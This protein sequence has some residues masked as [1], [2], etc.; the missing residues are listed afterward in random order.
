MAA[1]TYTT[2]L[3]TL[4]TGNDV[5]NWDE[6]SNSSWDDASP[7]VAESDFYIQGTECISA[8]FTKDGVGTILYLNATSV[9]VPTPGAMLLWHS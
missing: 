7:P 9:V 8:Q 6:S 5:A 1:P 2:D 4:S 3:I